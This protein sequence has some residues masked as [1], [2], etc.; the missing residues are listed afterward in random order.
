MLKGPFVRQGCWILFAA[1]SVISFPFIPC[2][3]ATA[4]GKY[5]PAPYITDQR[6]RKVHE[7]IVET[8][9]SNTP[10]IS[11]ADARQ[12]TA[13]STLSA[14]AKK[15]GLP[16][17]KY[18][19]LPLMRHYRHFVKLSE[20]EMTILGVVYGWHQASV[21]KDVGEEPCMQQVRDGV[22]REIRK[23]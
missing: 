21:L 15:C 3:G 5:D 2:E 7:L 9:G 10:S 8:A 13:S 1:F 4:S 23:R 11:L 19:Y 18:V 12:I 20:H 6:V 16:W 22:W 14:L 17:D